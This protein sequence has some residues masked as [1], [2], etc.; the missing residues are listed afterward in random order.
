[1]LV[2]SPSAIARI[3]IAFSFL[4]IAGCST[5]ETAA[6]HTRDFSARHPVITA[7]GAAIV[8]GGAVAAI[9]AGHHHSETHPVGPERPVCGRGP[10]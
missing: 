3:S 1:M 7:V 5:L 9:E 10:C 4:T 2:R 6:D 8:V